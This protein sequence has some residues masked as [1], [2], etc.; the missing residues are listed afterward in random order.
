MK[1]SGKMGW[2]GS[3]SLFFPNNFGKNKDQKEETPN[4]HP[5][6]PSKAD[7]ALMTPLV[8]PPIPKNIRY[9]DWSHDIFEKYLKGIN[10]QLLTL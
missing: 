2:T 7:I 5:P 4:S 6:R 10:L 1:F 8:L 3:R 9:L